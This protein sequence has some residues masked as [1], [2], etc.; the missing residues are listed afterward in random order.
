MFCCYLP[1]LDNV[2]LTVP[3][4]PRCGGWLAAYQTTQLEDGSGDEKDGLEV[5][6]FVGFAPR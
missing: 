5:E 3:V 1:R 2:S 4:Y 6:V